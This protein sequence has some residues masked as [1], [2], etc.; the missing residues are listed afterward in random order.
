MPMVGIPNTPI[1]AVVSSLQGIRGIR[2]K[3]RGT[4]VVVARSGCGIIR[5]VGEI[6][7][8]TRVRLVK[9]IRIV[10]I[11]III[12]VIVVIV[13][14]IIIRI[15]I[16]IGR[17]P[18]LIRPVG[19]SRAGIKGVGATPRHSQDVLPLACGVKLSATATET[20]CSDQ[21]HC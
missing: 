13:I 10:K 1:V 18:P 19:P 7:V 9:I 21:Q 12:V 11:I 6:R 2:I 14:V 20:N 16:V 8:I 15:R 5:A 4:T 3:P 17:V